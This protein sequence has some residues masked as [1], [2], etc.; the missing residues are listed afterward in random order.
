MA[1][2]QSSVPVSNRL[3]RRSGAR[4]VKRCTDAFRPWRS[5]ATIDMALRVLLTLEDNPYAPKVGRLL[6][7]ASPLEMSEE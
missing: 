5:V 4:D 1:A 7:D 2:A 3:E 6:L